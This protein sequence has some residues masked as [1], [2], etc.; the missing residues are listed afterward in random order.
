MLWRVALCSCN[1]TLPVDAAA[2][3]RALGLDEAPERFDRLPRDQIHRFMDWLG[4]ER[5]DRVVVGCCAPAELIRE[6]ASAAGVAPSVVD[7]VN[8]RE[9][10]FW[11]HPDPVTAS[12]KAARLLR[13][14]MRTAVTT[15]P[16]SG[17]PV[18]VGTTVLIASDSPAGIAL[19]HRLGALARPILI[20]D[21]R[22]SRFDGERARALP[23]KV[24]WGRVVK[25]DGA[26]GA[27]RV[28]VEHQQPIDLRACIYCERCV[29][30]CHTS[31]IS[32]GLRLRMELCDQCG[33]CLEAC[34]HVGAI[35]I[36]RAER[37]AISAGQV[38]VIG[39]DGIHV[40]DGRRARTGH[41]RLVEPSPADL[42]ALSLKIL[43]LV[44][45]FQKPAYVHYDPHTC[46][47]GAAGRQACGR[48]V[49]ACPYDAIARD[50]REPLRVMVDLAG[51]EGCGACV[52][53]CPTSSLTFA[54]P[55]PAVVDARLRALLAPLPGAPAAPLV[56]AYHCPEQGAST[57]DDAG[58]ARRSF[59]PSVLPMSMACLRHVSEADLL[60]A[61]RYGAAGV[62]LVGCEACPHGE[63]QAL[64]D[65]LAVVKIVLEAFGLGG[66]RVQM[67]TGEP[68]EA[69]AGLGRFAA[70]LAPSPVRWDG[71][72]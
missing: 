24:N 59:S 54:D 1:E 28:T 18:K 33:D 55:A 43:G 35:K 41:H 65:R 29:P 23:W 61:F 3:Q 16:V 45:E 25:V 26:L 17:I 21:E 47:G 27:F 36:P 62:A 50:P 19:A 63:R 71:D 39:S 8:L 60:T 12:A 7:V 14:A 67:I 64:L 68:V 52:A 32:H 56:V 37:E 46:A 38:V 4:R 22:S 9:G 11:M 15:R 48:C 10:C 51:C 13:A 72:G 66:D 6:A 53:V 5:P 70:A 57:L 30:V 34:A 69:V 2:V 31:A 40:A 44:G 58:R 49:P 20:L 42:D